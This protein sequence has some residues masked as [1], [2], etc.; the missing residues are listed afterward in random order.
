[1]R[2][3]SSLTLAL[4]TAALAGVFASGCSDEF[5]QSQF[6]DDEAYTGQTVVP[7][8]PT[9]WNRDTASVSAPPVERAAPAAEPALPVRGGGRGILQQPLGVVHELDVR[10]HVLTTLLDALLRVLLRLGRLFV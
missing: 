9:V 5:D 1:M 10:R 6:P 2:E 7:P 8:V 4:F 3:S